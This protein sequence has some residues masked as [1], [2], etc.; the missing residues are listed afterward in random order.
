MADAKERVIVVTGGASG[1]GEACAEMLAQEG[2]RVV[3][4]DINLEAA[5]AVAGR[6][7]GIACHMDV[8]S[9]ESV[10]KAAQ[11]IG[12]QAGPVY[13]LVNS[14]GV[15]QQPLEPYQL[16]M[17][18]FDK[19]Q[20]VDFRGTYIACLAFARG[21]LARKTGSIV[22]I[23]SVAGSRSMPLHSYSPAK[24]AVISMTQCLAAEWGAS[25]VRVNSVAPGYTLTPA[26]QAAIDRKERQ[27]DG[28]IVNS[29]LP[30]LVRPEEIANAVA[31]L[32]SDKASAITGVDL[33][34]DCGWL[35]GTTWDMYGGLR[36]PA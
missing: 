28:A 22:N 20:A 8:A 25:G 34:V 3:V 1:I 31:F 26:L 13:G 33:P 4:A 10:E 16:G 19:V 18:A 21:M 11:E 36:R 14:A 7:G 12:K 30:R 24:A 6:I 5:Q 2:H 27:V 9:D 32:L 17:A 15:I 35:V 29:P 23:S